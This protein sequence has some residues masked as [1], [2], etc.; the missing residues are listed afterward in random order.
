M[1]SSNE[2]ICRAQALLCQCA[3]GSTYVTNKIV[4]ITLS[5]CEYNIKCFISTQYGPTVWHIKVALGHACIAK[6]VILICLFNIC[7]FSKH[8]DEDELFLHYDICHCNPS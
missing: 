6:P 3:S 1:C 8:V 2:Y 5:R 7:I 4:L